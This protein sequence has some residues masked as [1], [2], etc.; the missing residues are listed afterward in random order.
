MIM[1]VFPLA[2]LPNRDRSTSFSIQT[3]LIIRYYASVT[4]RESP[5]PTFPLNNQPTS[6]LSAVPHDPYNKYININQM[7]TNKS[8]ERVTEECLKILKTETQEATQKWIAD[9]KLTSLQLR[10]S[11]AL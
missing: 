1:K 3:K 6:P 11:K 8:V 10:N 7:S 4:N 2:R 9:S 5:S